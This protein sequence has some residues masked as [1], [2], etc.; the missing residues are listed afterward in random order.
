MAE[1]ELSCKKTSATNT[2]DQLYILQPVYQKQNGG[3]LQMYCKEIFIFFILFTAV[4]Y[5]LVIFS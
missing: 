3:K 4:E 5:R 2:S 1:E